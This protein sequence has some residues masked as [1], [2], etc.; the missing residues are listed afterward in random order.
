M[1]NQ[2]RLPKFIDIESYLSKW[3]H[4]IQHRALQKISPEKARGHPIGEEKEKCTI[5]NWGRS[6]S[7]RKQIQMRREDREDRED[8]VPRKY[9]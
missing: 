9:G 4:F 2:Q 1:L 7:K 3:R 6:Y 5:E 8:L